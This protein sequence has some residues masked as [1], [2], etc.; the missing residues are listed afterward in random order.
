MK[1]GDV[2]LAPFPFTDLSQT[3]LR[4]A[5]VLYVFPEGLDVTLCFISSRNLDSIDTTELLLSE[6]NPEFVAT[7]LK[8]TSKVRSA[9]V[10]TVERKLITRKLGTLGSQYLQRLDE[11]LIQAFQLSLTET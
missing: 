4:P 9:R 3:K 10:V 1:K 11:A 7:G 8:T 6:S 5:V 2:V